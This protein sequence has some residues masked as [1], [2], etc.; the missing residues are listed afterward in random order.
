MERF[1]LMLT[2]GLLA[3]LTLYLAI[4]L[5]MASELQPVQ[6]DV[7]N[8]INAPAPISQEVHYA[9]LTDAQPQ[10]DITKQ[11]FTLQAGN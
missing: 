10:R 1:K 3:V 7:S 11:H 8:Q 2:G 5:A 4:F 9:Q 6:A